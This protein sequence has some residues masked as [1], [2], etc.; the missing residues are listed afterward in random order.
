MIRDIAQPDQGLIHNPTRV[1]EKVAG[2]P[3]QDLARQRRKKKEA[4]EKG[5]RYKLPGVGVKY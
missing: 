3:V 1:I 2:L 4:I 5:E